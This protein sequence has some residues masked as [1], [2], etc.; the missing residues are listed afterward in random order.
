MI[1]RTRRGLVAAAAATALVAAWQIVV[2]VQP[3]AAP[4]PAA[5][6]A[7]TVA[8][9][10]AG[11]TDLTTVGAQGGPS[12]PVAP[13]LVTAASMRSGTILVPSAGIY[14][15]YAPEPVVDGQ[16]V[17]PADTAGM[18]SGGA[19]P[20]DKAGTVLLWAHV[21][22]AF[23]GLYR[24]LP[25]GVVYVRDDAGRLSSWQITRIYTE[26]RSWTHPDLYTA[27]GP[28]QL[29]LVTCGGSVEW[30]HYTRN[31]IVIAQEVR[32]S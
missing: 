25:N 10:A 16:A 11:P 12:A 2:A 1:R 28:H 27:T 26:P 32:T 9:V 13:T 8:P 22:H 7:T 30:G 31:I 4:L 17:V 24:S 6:V 19:H 3:S 20:S 29:A 21:E 15:T 18:W 14:T 5:M 23:A